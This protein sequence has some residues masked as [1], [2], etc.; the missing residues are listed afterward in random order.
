ME[1]MDRLPIDGDHLRESKV[2]R[3]IVFYGKVPREIPELQT[4]AQKLAGKKTFA[5]FGVHLS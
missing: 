3:I 1:I 2:G 4:K 5:V